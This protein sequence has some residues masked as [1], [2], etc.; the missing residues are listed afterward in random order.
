MVS[1]TPQY[2]PS[3]FFDSL[4]SLEDLERVTDEFESLLL[5]NSYDADQILETL[6]S[7]ER[8]EIVR[9]V[10]SRM[11]FSLGLVHST[12]Y[13]QQRLTRLGL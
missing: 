11:Y 3:N 13:L 8:P 9:L 12:H 6:V 1:P 7:Q 10:L 5:Y 4:K 2:Y